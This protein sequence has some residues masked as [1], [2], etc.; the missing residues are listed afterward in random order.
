MP[1]TP[2]ERA[3]IARENGAKSKGPV[4]PEG[5]AAASRNAM[6][7]G[8]HASTHA[9]YKPH[10]TVLSNEDRQEFYRLVDELIE[11]YAPM[12]QIT[13]DIVNQIARTRWQIERLTNCLTLQ[14]QFA[15]VD[16]V[17]QPLGVANDLAEAKVM[18]LSSHAVYSTNGVVYR[19]NRQIDQLGQRIA[20]LERRIDFVHRHFP[21]AAAEPVEN[22][23]VPPPTPENE[24]ENEPV[25]YITE[26]SP[27]VIE[28]YRLRYP[29]RKIVVLPPDNV[30]RGIDEPDDLPNVPRKAA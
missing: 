22:K 26:N 23:E 12:N 3:R 24:A 25:I 9:I 5:K 16:A 17:Q 4:T 11:I 13:R 21:N 27:K 18:T 6:K 20:R 30:A 14:W 15:M 1:R 8:E 2:E 19:M 29:G 28:A 7:N 10:H